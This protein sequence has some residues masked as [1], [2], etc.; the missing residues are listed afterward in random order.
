MWSVYSLCVSGSCRDL[1]KCR[2]WFRVGLELHISDKISADAAGPPISGEEQE[3]QDSLRPPPTPQLSAESEHFLSL[4][5]CSLLPALWMQLFLVADSTMSRGRK[6]SLVLW[7]CIALET[8]DNWEVLNKEN[9][10]EKEGT[11]WAE[12]E[13]GGGG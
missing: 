5:I 4:A 7:V 11:V 6:P 10:V 12:R 8:F 9:R 3:L 2:F 1:V 13:R